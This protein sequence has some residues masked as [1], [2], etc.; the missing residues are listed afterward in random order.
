[1]LGLFATGLVGVVEVVRDWPRA[2]T[3]NIGL[4]LLDPAAR[5]RG[6]GAEI[7]D[8]VDAWATANGAATLRISVDPA[9]VDGMRF[10]QRH[11]FSPVPSVGTHPTAVALE[12]PVAGAR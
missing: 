6:A 12:R 9:N 4:L 8:A 1:M 7:L 3:Q 10:W 5:G 11:G 2:G